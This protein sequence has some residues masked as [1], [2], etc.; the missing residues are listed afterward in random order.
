MQAWNDFIKQ[1]ERILGK[2]CVDKW[3][4]TLKVVKFDACN[5]Y[6]EAENSLQKVFFDEHME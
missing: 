2:E 6:L 5:L 1:Q 4:R 3:L